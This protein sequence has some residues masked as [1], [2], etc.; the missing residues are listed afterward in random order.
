MYKGK[1][2]L[3]CFLTY[4]Y[5][6]EER[7]MKMGSYKEGGTIACIQEELFVRCVAGEEDRHSMQPEACNEA[8]DGKQGILLICVLPTQGLA[9]TCTDS[10]I[11]LVGHMGSFSGEASHVASQQKPQTPCR[12]PL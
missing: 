1:E 3:A 8:H 2:V 4:A 12:L 6:V 5:P 9:V 11:F 10:G 7:K